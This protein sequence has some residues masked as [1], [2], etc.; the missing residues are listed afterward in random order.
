MIKA[1]FFPAKQGEPYLFFSVYPGKAW[2]VESNNR[3]TG[4]A[5]G[6]VGNKYN[7]IGPVVAS[8]ITDTKILI[9]KA[10]DKLI[11]QP[12]LL[13]YCL[14]KKICNTRLNSKGIIKLRHFIR[15]Y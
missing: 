11:N 2:N 10:L 13:M 9:T 4:F 5:L 6:R 15:M 1:F 8:K 3:I 14:I 12:V 7:Q